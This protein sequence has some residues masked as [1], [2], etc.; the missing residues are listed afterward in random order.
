MTTFEESQLDFTHPVRYR[1]ITPVGDDRSEPRPILLALHGMGM[2]APRFQRVLR[3]L[4]TT[5]MIL[6]V[7]E[8]MYPYEI[9]KDNEITIGHAW[10]LYRGDQE[11]FFGHLEESEQYL[12]RLLDRIEAQRP[13]DRSRSVVLGFSQGGYL[14]GFMALR[15]PDRFAGLAIASSRLKWEFVTEEIEARRVP[16]TLFL[17]SKRDGSI[18]WER[19]EESAKRLSDA[20]SDVAIY[21]HDEGHRLPPDAIVRLGE[22]LGEH[23]FDAGYREAARVKTA[24]KRLEEG[25]PEGALEFAKGPLE[26]GDPEA[27][28]LAAAASL[29][30]EELS[31]ARGYLEAMTAKEL[32]GDTEYLRRFYLGQTLFLLGY[33]DQAIDALSPLEPGDPIERANIEWWTG[34]C[35]DHL[36]K[37]T[38]A[39]ACFAKAIELDPDGA[40]RPTALSE[41]EVEAVVAEVAL[42]LPPALQK[43][44][45]EV[46]VVIQDLPPRAAIQS[47]D[48]VLAPDTLGLYSGSSLLE[49]SVL[50][51]APF[52]PTI[53]IFR[54]NLE[55]FATGDEDM[56]AQIRVTLLHE[57]GHHLGY[58][59]E[60]LDRLGLA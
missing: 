36:G 53:F 38:R 44:F 52:P 13:I 27:M 8:G 35:Y 19:V 34:L 4:E 56:R 40:P 32:D 15:Q 22:W 6:V 57:L 12:L 20:G 60:D 37:S 2:N 25:N 50:S 30:L 16:P 23:G 41:D 51:E 45:E 5:E 7:P 43:V 33:P 18:P 54:R 55:R 39:D 10:Y 46:P 1:V 29:D 42:E 47:S 17:H 26:E 21:G 59:E 58:D 24:W 49:R 11:E 28:L 9:R 14:A 31:R 3:H 48:G